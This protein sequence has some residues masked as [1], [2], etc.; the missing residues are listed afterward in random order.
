MLLIL[1]SLAGVSAHSQS[2]AGSAALPLRTAVEIALTGNAQLQAARSSVR[3]AEEQ[4]REVY[5]GVFPR[6][7]A[8]ASYVRALGAWS[9]RVLPGADPEVESDTSNSPDNIWSAALNLNQLVNFQVFPAIAAARHLM[10]LRG[11]QRRGAA[12]QV[13]GQVRQRYFDALLAEQRATLTE[14]SIVRTRQTLSEARAR[15]AEGLASDDELLRAEVQFTILETRLLVARNQVAAARGQL[16]LTIGADPLRAIELSG[17]LSELRLEAGAGNSAENVE[18]L[19]ASGA[20]A[21]AAA[22]EEQL[23]QLAFSSR[24]DLRQLRASEALAEQQVAV[25][26]SEALPI[27]RA[28]GSVGLQIAD[29]DEDDTFGNP[30]PGLPGP[31]TKYSQWDLSAS[32]GLSVQV[33]IFSGFSRL[34]RL[35]TRRE[36]LRRATNALRQAEREMV[37]QVRTLAAALREARAR[38]AGMRLAV[39]QAQQSYEIATTRYGAGVGD[40]FEVLAAETTLRESEFNY[41]QAVYDYLTAA[42]QLEVAT[43]QVPMAGAPSTPASQRDG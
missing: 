37:H 12:H 22:S 5:S 2:L 38:A 34:A 39:A 8:E 16:L 25:Q 20:A 1:L 14:Q 18:L 3:I 33:P 28:F 23:R 21:L 27:I 24:S 17:S 42:S 19:A 31:Q 10:E 41:A 35:E 36:E 32:A 15:H 29:N 9:Q 6:V 13:V 43:G 11:E 40:Q 26:A 30:L 4:I 7:S